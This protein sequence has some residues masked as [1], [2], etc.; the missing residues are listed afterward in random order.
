VTYG[1][2]YEISH[3]LGHKESPNKYKNI[4]IIPSI[5]FDYNT[6]KLEFNNKRNSRKYSNT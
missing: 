3:I 6:I 5:L 2:F 1:T 4:E